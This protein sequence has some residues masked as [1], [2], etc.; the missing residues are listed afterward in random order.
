MEKV[1]ILI[2]GCTVLPMKDKRVI[3]D[4]IIA[5][6]GEKIVFV[7]ENSSLSEIKAERTIDAR[8]KVALPGLV[9]CHTHVAM[10]L[11]RGLAEDKSLDVWLRE[12]IWPLEAKLTSEDVY[13]GA[14]LGCLEILKSGTTCFADMYFHE[15]A[16]AEAVRQT[17]IRGVLAEGII[18][19]GDKALGEK[20]LDNSVRFAMEFNGFAQGR[21]ITMLAPHAAYSCSPELLEK[22]KEK[23]SK[24]NVGVHIHLAES[25]EMF[26]EIERLYNCSEVEFLHRLGFFDGHVLAAHCIDLSESDR[27]ILAEH[28]VNVVHVPAANMKL[29]LGAAKV[30]ELVDLGVNVALGTDGPASNNTLD[31]FEAMKFAALLQKHVYRDPS[32]LSA[33]QVLKMATLNGAKALGLDGIIG[34]LEV[35]KRADIVLVDLSKPHLTPVHDVYA[36][37]V[38]SARGSDVDTVIVDGEVLMENRRVQKLNEK[39]VIEKA[40]KHAADLLVRKP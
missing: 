19:A 25:T 10:T 5:V 27:R 39:T 28:D 35:G 37:L 38:Y 15:R 4:G 24:L 14:L 18:E 16:V 22:V 1:D 3:K 9:N 30:K 13:A 31:M 17:G 23:A 6:K 32:V 7:G 8:G 26:R 2:R 33:Y 36:T 34:S 12:A 11:F 29:G 20:M 21:V 40:E